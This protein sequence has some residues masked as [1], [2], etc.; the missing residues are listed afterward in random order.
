MKSILF[1]FGWERA[2]GMVLPW[3][4]NTNTIPVALP[5]DFVLELP[6]SKD[7]VGG[8]RV[9]FTGD[10]FATYTKVFAKPAAWEGKRVLLNLDG[11]Y[12]CAEIVLNKDRIG[13]HPYGYTPYTL[14]I[15]DQLRSDLDN[16][17]EITTQ[18]MQP[19]TRWYSGG[20]LYR[21]VTLWI[22]EPVYLSPL[23]LVVS[24]PVVAAEQAVVRVLAPVTN[25]LK[26]NK[27]VHVTAVLSYQGETAAC[28]ETTLVVAAGGKQ[29]AELF[30]TV[31][32][33]KLWDDIDPRL[34]DLEIRVQ[35]EGLDADVT[36][37]KIG[38]RK[39][40]I[41]AEE[42][43]KINGR[44]ITLFGG[45]I[46]HDNGLLGAR[47][48]PRAEERKIRNLKAAGFNAIRTAHN[49]S[50]DALLDACDRLG[51]LVLDEFF[52][53][54]RTGKNQNDYH[55]WFEDWWKRDIEYTV[56]RDRNHPSVYCWSFGNEIQEA[57][58]YSN[59]E[60]WMK[61]QADWIRTLDPTRLVTCGGMFLPK[62]MTCDGFPGGP[63]GPP[64]RIDPYASEE[65]T[66][67]RW[68]SMISNLDIVS[69][70]YSFRN[71]AQFHKLFPNKVLQGTETE[72]I[73]AWGNRQA[74]L[75]NKHVVG[76]FMWTA[77]DNLG[78]A[79][80][81]RS[82]WEE[83]KEKTGLMAGWPWLSCYQGDLALDGERLPRSYYR[84]VIW[85]KDPG[86]HVFTNPPQ[87]AGRKVM[88]TGFH[89]H[90][91]RPLWTYPEAYIGHDI[92]VEAYADCDKVEFYVN[93]TLAA[94]AEPEESIFYA[95]VTYQPGTLRA[96]AYKNGEKIAED[97]LTTTGHATSIL[98]EADGTP[99]VADGMELTYVTAT[100]VD[101][102]GQRVY[103]E[104]I[105][106]KAEVSG[107]AV[108]E[109]FGSNNPCTEE[110]FGT[111]RRRTWNGKAT[112][113]L[114]A[115]LK[116]GEAVLTVSSASLPTVQ[117]RFTVR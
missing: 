53:C 85:G 30:M 8:A 62:N 68:I 11:A 59:C 12:M 34:Y 26:E 44:P 111:G 7:A 22:G 32:D 96:V 100:L 57:N 70:N 21:N 83:E 16:T 99:L 74:I 102:K 60:Y 48:L 23:D 77:H 25:T 24:T 72:G 78:E 42:G 6:R 50:S 36:N 35:A 17:L 14:D 65:E 88:G 66:N 110:N 40:T 37:K 20:G 71:Y 94:T 38:L 67:R 79:G 43:M 93:G 52:D 106:L 104:D 103:D 86:V 41:S 58:G 98:L 116:P 84:A 31:L 114:R 109:G 64:A 4:K 49:P 46:H 63:G 75:N 107:A 9:G 90:D 27:T 117:S 95:T 101:D 87:Y 15:T 47:A 45:C 10:H 1:N 92:D 55:Q 82:Y 19:S 81:G 76:D 28:A 3:E 69:L 97:T 33:P 80:A 51:M 54:W 113:V 73:D 2:L 112:L 29:D 91:V 61:T 56:R 13:M 108:L 89:W 105:E 5:D 39:I 18:T 115:G